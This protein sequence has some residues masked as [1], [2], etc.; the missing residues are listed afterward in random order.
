[1]SDNEEPSNSLP[2]RIIDYKKTYQD[3]PAR[4]QI[5]F[6]ESIKVEENG[7]FN[8]WYSKWSLSGSKFNRL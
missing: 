2:Q 1:M 8:V 6:A 5:E 7:S 3:R 4:V